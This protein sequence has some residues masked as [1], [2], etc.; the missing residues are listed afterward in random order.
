MTPGPGI[1]HDVRM[2][3]FVERKSFAEVWKIIQDRI[4]PGEAESTSLRDACDRVL[5]EDV[6]S[7]VA[8][9]CFDRSAMDGY[10][11][12]AEETSGASD[13]NPLEFQVIGEA[14]PGRAFE[15]R[16]GPGQA[17]KV[18]T[19]AAIPDGANAV[20]MAEYAE[21]EASRVRFRRQVTP[22]KNI[23]RAGEDVARGDVVL[24]RGRRLR[25]Q[26]IGVLASV[27]R[28]AVLAYRSPTVAVLITGNELVEPGQAADGTCIVD[29]NSYVIGGLVR[30]Y[31]GIPMHREIL[32]DR[33]ETIRAA[34]RECREDLVVVSGG[35]SV[36][37]EDYAPGIVRELGELV[38]HG[39]AIK[40]GSPFGLG[41][42]DGRAVFLLPGS[43]VAAMV[44]ADAF[45]GSAIRR[46]LG[47]DVGFAYPRLRCRLL[48]KVV[49][50]IGRTEFVRVHLHEDFTV[51]KLRV[52]GSSILT[53]TT[54]ADGFLVIDD[55]IEGYPEG[56][57]VDVY[58]Y[59]S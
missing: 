30:R 32:P 28:P 10:A 6:V 13:Y 36:G 17:V 16:A 1:Q 41:F 55:A 39:V 29:S 25:P 20:M 5:A 43:P 15:G 22:G 37:E 2:S 12:L 50:A 49:S 56:S 24:A 52:S 34:I 45:V 14:Y 33:A 11:V 27:H 48:Q 18:M 26:D 58:R 44:T 9:P 59:G 4:R 19:G 40:P 7:P 21:A 57:M 51:E 54:R 23:M 46:K 38:V 53:S 8:V 3:G 47:L 42:I 31:G 35:S